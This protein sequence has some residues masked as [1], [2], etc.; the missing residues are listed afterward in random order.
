MGSAARSGRGGSSGG[1]ID[2]GAG[3]LLVA[4]GVPSL[5]LPGPPSGQPRMQLW[6]LAQLSIALGEPSGDFLPWCG[7][8]YCLTKLLCRGPTACLPPH[9]PAAAAQL[10]CASHLASAQP[11]CLATRTQNG[12]LQAAEGDAMA[13]KGGAVVPEGDLFKVRR[14]SA[15]PAP[16]RPSLLPA[17]AA[18]IRLLARESR[19]GSNAH[20]RWT[21]A[22]FDLS[23]PEEVAGSTTAVAMSSRDFL[24]IGS[25]SLARS[26]HE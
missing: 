3:S 11:W 8:P 19:P 7:L 6:S 24:R 21:A 17:A 1:T 10:S 2:S 9:S 23:Q 16:R 25:C 18:Q 14:P 22:S 13:Q 12:S 20:G 26:S 5:L 4:A 15:P